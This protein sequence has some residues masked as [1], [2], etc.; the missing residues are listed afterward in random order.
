MMINN[1]SY[2][3]YVRHLSTIDVMPS[4][5]FKGMR[6]SNQNSLWSETIVVTVCPIIMSS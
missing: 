2:I 4:T 3:E 1:C 6:V 5:Y